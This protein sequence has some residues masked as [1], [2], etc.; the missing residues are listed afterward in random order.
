MAKLKLVGLDPSLTHWG[1]AIGSYDP[2]SNDLK[3]DHLDTICPVL[4]KG[5][6]VR[7]NNVDL[8]AA[9]QLYEGAC[10]AM[11]GAH[12]V[13]VEVPHGSQSARAMASYGI[14]VGVLAGLRAAG[15]PFFELNATEVKVATGL[16]KTAT[17]LEM[18]NWAASR[19]PEAPWQRHIHD[20][21]GKPSKTNPF[22]MVGS[23]KKGELTNSNEHQAD[24][25]AAIH[26][27]LR[28]NAFQQLLQLAA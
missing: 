1:I 3:I 21:K 10:D 18:I 28:L 20:A 22:V 5:K 16:K 24:A 17:K 6:Q 14:C 27:G 2:G 19:H 26:A 8:T 12:A 23:Y 4:F 25:V 7:Q 11:K 9:I 15:H 13:F